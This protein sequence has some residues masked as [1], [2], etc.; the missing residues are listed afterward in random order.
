MQ[1]AVVASPCS[2]LLPKVYLC[3][4]MKTA[5]FGKP[6]NVSLISFDIFSLLQNSRFNFPD[7]LINADTRLYTIYFKCRSFLVRLV[8][9]PT[10]ITSLAKSSA[11]V[12]C[13]CARNFHVGF[14]N[15]ICFTEE[16]NQNCA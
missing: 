12:V 1:S 9:K 2:I 15:Q 5:F 6:A 11:F 10:F 13:A 16:T 4:S 7:Y 8:V 14:N 3:N